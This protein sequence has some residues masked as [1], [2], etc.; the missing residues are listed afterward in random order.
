MRGALPPRFKLQPAQQFAISSAARAR[1][2]ALVARLAAGPIDRLLHRVGG[3]H[4]ECDG[5][6]RFERDAREPGGALAGDIVEMR[7]LAADHGAERD[8][9]L[10]AARQREFARDHG[11]VEGARNAHDLDL[12]VRRPMALE[13]IQRAPQQRLD[14]EI[15]EPRDHQGE[16]QIAHEELAFDY[17]SMARSTLVLSLAARAQY[18]RARAHS[19]PST[20]SVISR[21]KAESPCSCFGALST[22]M[23]FSP[24]S[25]SICAPMP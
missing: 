24:R 12:L 3:Q 4:A 20:Y 17:S 16:A 22:R 13:R 14:H 8:Q 2:R 23:R 1:V 18:N 25:L 7:R 10:V 21:S 5:H 11:H 6:A 9:R 15:V 19:P